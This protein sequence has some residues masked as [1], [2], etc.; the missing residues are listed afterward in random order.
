MNDSI[1]VV[2]H[3]CNVNDLSLVVHVE[4]TTT[5]LRIITPNV[6]E[7]H[8]LHKSWHLK[9]IHEPQAHYQHQPAEIE[10][11][12]TQLIVRRQGLQTGVA[13]I[14]VSLGSVLR[15]IPLS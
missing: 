7:L 3:S 1:L 4:G 9:N 10:S 6:S 13:H 11:H 8:W 14:E 15:S 5:D 12:S 2:L